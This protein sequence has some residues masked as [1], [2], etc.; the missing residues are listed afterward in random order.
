[1]VADALAA[2]FDEARFV[3]VVFFILVGFFVGGVGVV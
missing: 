2:E 1:M 3:G